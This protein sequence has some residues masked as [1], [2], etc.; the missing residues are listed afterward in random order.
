MGQWGR[1]DTPWPLKK[2]TPALQRVF[3]WGRSS[4]GLSMKGT[5]RTQR[6]FSRERFTPALMS[7]FYMVL[8][9]V[10]VAL[11]FSLF[12]VP[13]NLA[14]GGIT[15][16]SI[17]LRRFVDLPPG[18]LYFVLNLPLLWVG[19]RNL[20]RWQFLIRT[21][22]CVLVFSASTDLLSFLMPRVLPQ[23]PMTENMLLG[24]IYA[25]LVT[26]IGSGVIYR[27]G[28]TIGGT[29]IISRIIQ[30]KSGIPLSQIYLMVDGSIIL[31]A[32]FTFG[33]EIALHAVLLVL[34]SGIA[35]DFALEGPSVVR[36]ASIVTDRP[37]ELAS[38]LMARLQR[39]VSIWEVTGGYT[40]SKRAMV[41]CT[42]NRAQIHELRQV[43][44][45]ATPE[46][47]MV[48]GDAH[49]ALGLG[50]RPLRAKSAT[51]SAG[52]PAKPGRTDESPEEEF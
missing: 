6:R 44:A 14:A 15:G 1:I 3:Y 4:K 13:Y 29:S 10:I 35:S 27:A 34:I 12:Q 26:G 41:F 7:H 38:V 20:G 25:G 23:F 11:G 39:G 37:Q 50:F 17:I 36:T 16:I 8:G 43:V 52:S 33:W 30:R 45:E 9:A 21:L 47:F 51:P 49:Q 19:F 46:A 22:A 48:I 2:T 42:V 32:V 31:I 40:G 18:L 24:A 28:G 5:G